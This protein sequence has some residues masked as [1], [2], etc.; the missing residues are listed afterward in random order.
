MGLKYEVAKYFERSDKDT[1]IITTESQDKSLVEFNKPQDSNLVVII[2]EG[3]HMERSKSR[4]I[5][6]VVR[7]VSYANIPRRKIITS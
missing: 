5:N 3:S 2:G 7:T 4:E 1:D 6:P